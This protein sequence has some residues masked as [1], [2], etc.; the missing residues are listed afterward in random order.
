MYPGNLVEGLDDVGLP[1]VCLVV[2]SSEYLSVF[3]SVRYLGS[4]THSGGMSSFEFEVLDDGF[5]H[6]GCDQIPSSIGVF[7]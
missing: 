2:R 6:G 7:L 3:I 5:F 4:S 1:L